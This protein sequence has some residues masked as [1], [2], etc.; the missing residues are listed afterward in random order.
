MIRRSGRL[1][2][3]GWLE[4]CVCVWVTIGNWRS[5]NTLLVLYIHVSGHG[6]FSDIFEGRE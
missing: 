1:P 3:S 5:N 6:E 2:G 4:G